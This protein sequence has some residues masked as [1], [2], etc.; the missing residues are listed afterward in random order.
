[1]GVGRIGLNPHRRIDVKFFKC[2]LKISLNFIQEN[3]LVMQYY[4][5]LDQT[6]S[7]EA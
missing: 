3:N 4:I 5:L 7:T 1:M 2:D 6:T